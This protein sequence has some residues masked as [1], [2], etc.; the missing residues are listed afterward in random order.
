MTEVLQIHSLFFDHWHHLPF[1]SIS[2][3]DAM[4]WIS[5]H[6]VIT[7]DSFCHAIYL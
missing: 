2:V 3:R 6:L 4:D 5:G 7:T 1:S